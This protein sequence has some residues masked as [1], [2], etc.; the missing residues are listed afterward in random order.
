M[1]IGRLMTAVIVLV[2]G[3][4]ES[5]RKQAYDG[6]SRIQARHLR[7]WRLLGGSNWDQSEKELNLPNLRW[8][9]LA[10]PRRTSWYAGPKSFHRKRPVRKKAGQRKE[11]RFAM[12]DDEEDEIEELKRRTQARSRYREGD[13]RSSSW[14]AR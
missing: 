12:D 3:R 1:V 9:L 7:S 5:P 4:D 6:I 8:R 2:I 10:V 13:R 11:V 14:K